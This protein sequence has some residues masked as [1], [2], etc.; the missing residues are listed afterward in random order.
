MADFEGRSRDHEMLKYI[1]SILCSGLEMYSRL[2]KKY[3]PCQLWL[4]MKI[5]KQKQQASLKLMYKFLTLFLCFQQ[6]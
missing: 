2:R 6:F 4:E 1:M 3:V 5:Q